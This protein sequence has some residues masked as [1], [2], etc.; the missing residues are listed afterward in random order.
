MPKKVY[1]EAKFEGKAKIFRSAGQWVVRRKGTI[2]GHSS[3]QTTVCDN[4][5]AAIKEKFK[6]R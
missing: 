2:N 1:V 5:F 4:L 3:V 6:N